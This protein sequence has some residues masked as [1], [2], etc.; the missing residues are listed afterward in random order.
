MLADGQIRW[1]RW[2][3]RAIFDE[4]GSL[5]EY[6]SVGRDVTEQ[7]RAE[8]AL[9]QSERQLADIINF[10]PDATLVIDRQGKVIAWNKAIE[11]MTGIPAAEMVGKGD[12][13]YAI[14]F[15]GVRR[16][17]LI[18]LIFESEDTIARQYYK[19]IHKKGAL[20]IAETDLPRLK[21]RR[22]VLWGKASPLY[23]VTG[24]IIG[25]IESIRDV[26]E[27]REMEDAIK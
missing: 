7:K 16:P 27:R 24:K 22:A 18:D 25:A 10:L 19:I 6:Q 14:P 26:T 13:E 20:L 11:E 15:Y 2:S 23:D 21:G 4:N 8:I 17:I 3:D 9:V 12:Y 5:A 1:Q